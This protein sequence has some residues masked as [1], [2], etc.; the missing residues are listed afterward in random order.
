MDEDFIPWVSE[1]KDQTE[2]LIKH[3]RSEQ[4]ANVMPAKVFGA[5]LVAAYTLYLHELRGNIS[6]KETQ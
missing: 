3:F 5:S 2:T 6:N 1:A 4:K